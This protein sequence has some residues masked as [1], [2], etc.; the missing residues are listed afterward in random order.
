MDEDIVRDVLVRDVMSTPVIYIHP[1]HTV[2][3]AAA[4]MVEK[5]VGS[6]VV[7]DDA[8]RLIGIVTRT[9]ILRHVVAKGLN[10]DKVTISEVMTR[11]PIYV[12]SDT[13]LEEA[14]RL[15][16][17]KGIGHLPVLDSKT[18]KPIG[19]ISKRDILKIAPHYIV[20]VY[21]LRRESEL[22]PS[23]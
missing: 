16:G 3:E 21:T 14:A 17:S 13:P 2:R 15:M 18:F 6:L 4:I 20:L 10:P 8:G 7:V 11:N 9:D 1:F 23:L 12:L 22:T 5:N 19:M